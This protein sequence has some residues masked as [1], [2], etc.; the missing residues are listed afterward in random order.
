MTTTAVKGREPSKLQQMDEEKDIEGLVY[1]RWSM[2]DSP[3]SPGS[4]Y[5]FME[6]DTVLLLDRV[7]HRTRMNL[8]IE[9]GYTSKRYAD[10]LGLTTDNSHRIGKAVRIRI[11]HPKKRMRLVKALI[12]EGVERI[13]LKL[14]AVYFDTDNQKKEALYLW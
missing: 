13:G 12:L 14:D 3:D 1:L 10:I 9:L 4:G 7:V 5:R 11:L 2:F 8:N 6:R